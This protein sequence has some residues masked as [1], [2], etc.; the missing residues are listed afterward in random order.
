MLEGRDI[1]LLNFYGP[2]AAL[3]L[4]SGRS[5]GGLWQRAQPQTKFPPGS[6]GFRDDLVS[7]RSKGKARK[8]RGLGPG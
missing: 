1:L 6:A 7:L 5:A 8:W 4:E 2:A 3:V